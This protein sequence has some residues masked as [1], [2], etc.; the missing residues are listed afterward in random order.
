MLTS[1]RDLLRATIELYRKEFWLFLGYAA[2]LLVPAAAFYFAIALPPNPVTTVLIVVTVV[3]QLFV[4][5]WIFVCLMRATALLLSNKP[6]DHDVLSTQAL[7]R[8]QPVLAVVFLQALIVLGGTLLLIIPGIIFWVW[9]S[10][11]QTAAGLDDKR[12]VESLTFSRAL[13]QGRFTQVLW[14]LIAGPIVIG[15][16]YAFVS[17]AILVILARLLGVDVSII[18]S[19]APPLWSQIV[20]SIVDIFF[21]PLFLIYTVL[22]YQDLKSH[23]LEKGDAVA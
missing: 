15:L 17:G 3:L 22:L 10:L 21:I 6:I 23:P 18:F 19:D 12:P 1:P 4:W 9:Y 11:A 16:L 8:I 7:R 20:Q 2:W 13:V 14:R 5:L